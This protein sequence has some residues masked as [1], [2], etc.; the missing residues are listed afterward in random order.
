MTYYAN[1]QYYGPSSTQYA[2]SPYETSPTYAPLG[3]PSTPMY[4]YA[5]SDG[6][7]YTL[8]TPTSPDME[9]FAS[10][11][12]DESQYYSG[13]YTY[14]AESSSTPQASVGADHVSLSTVDE[15]QGGSSQ[16]NRDYP[17]MC[18]FPGCDKTF[19]RRADLDRH[20]KHRHCPDNSRVSY[21]CDYAKCGRRHD[22]FYRRDHYRDH[23]RDFHKEDIEKRGVTTNQ[24]WLEGRNVSIHWWRCHKCLSRVIVNQSQYDCPNCKTTCQPA[25]ARVRRRS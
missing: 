21:R 10:N 14:Q 4:R 13:G 22:P 1:S 3:S 25:R 24:E 8:S 11:W 12:Q 6:S 20:Y 7:S 2:Y 16:Q 19:K 5:S 9:N 18:L 17:V 15:E 23:L